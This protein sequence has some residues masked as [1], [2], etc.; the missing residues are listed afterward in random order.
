MV[1]LISHPG[2]LLRMARTPRPTFVNYGARAA[3]GAFGRL[4]AEQLDPSVGW[5]DVEWL[6]GQ[7]SADI[8]AFLISGDTDPATLHEAKAKGFFLLHKP[9]NPMALRAM[10][11]QAI[12]PVPRAVVHKLSAAE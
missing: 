7:W 12:K 6:R 8:P 1:D 5:R 10:F 9:V 2:W 11:N 3:I 4:M